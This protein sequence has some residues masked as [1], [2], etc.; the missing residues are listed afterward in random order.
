[1]MKLKA[2]LLSLEAH[3]PIVLLNKADAEDIDVRPLDRVD[4]RLGSKTTNAI[5][6]ITDHFIKSGEIGLY[7]KL[8]NYMKA[9]EN[10]I[11]DCLLYTSPSPRD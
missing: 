2:K 9:K 7:S 5:V 8:S 6:N 11:I 4:I 10:Q 3:K 1:M